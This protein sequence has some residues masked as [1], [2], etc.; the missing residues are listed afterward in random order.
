[1]PGRPP[2]HG[3][4]GDAVRAVPD[5]HRLFPTCSGSKADAEWCVA[6]R[7][8]FLERHHRGGAFLLSGQT[9]P[10]CEGR[11]DGAEDPLAAGAIVSTITAVDPALADLRGGA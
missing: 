1:M 7:V 5:L 8:A 6:A 11:A 3:S 9:V 2:R 10:P 4:D